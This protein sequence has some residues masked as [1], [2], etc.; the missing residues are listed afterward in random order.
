MYLMQIFY[1]PHKL[2]FGIHA[3]KLQKLLNINEQY[4]NSRNGGL[5]PAAPH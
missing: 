5:V 2:S 4:K 3:P 1:I